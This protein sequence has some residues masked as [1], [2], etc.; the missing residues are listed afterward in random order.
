MNSLG[1]YSHFGEP[2]D[3]RNGEL[4]FAIIIIEP[5]VLGLT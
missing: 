3:N 4:I 2:D 1:N 5:T